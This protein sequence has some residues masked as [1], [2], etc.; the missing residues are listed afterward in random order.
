MI[1]VSERITPLSERTWFFSV[2]TD[3]SGQVDLVL[4]TYEESTRASPRHKWCAV[5]RYSLGGSIRSPRWED[6]ERIQTDPDLP[7]WVEAEAR[8]LLMVSVR[9][10][11]R[12]R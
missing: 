12:F 9:V 3:L 4:S 1:V 7:E 11:R 2:H 10:L 8:R 6:V 5:R